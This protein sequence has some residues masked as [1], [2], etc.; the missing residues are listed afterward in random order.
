MQLLQPFSQPNAVNIVSNSA[1]AR[2]DSITVKVRKCLLA[3]PTFLSAFR[4][5]NMDGLANPDTRL[6][7]EHINPAAFATAS[8]FGLINSQFNFSRML[9]FGVRFVF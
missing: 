5:K 3:G 2:Y 6:L 7:S 9:R 1:R 8:S 4:S